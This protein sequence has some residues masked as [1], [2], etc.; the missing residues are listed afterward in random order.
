MAKW[1]YIVLYRR[2]SEINLGEE[3]GGGSV[4]SVREIGISLRR[5]EFAR[6]GGVAS[7]GA[8]QIIS[9]RFILEAL[10]ARLPTQSQKSAVP[11]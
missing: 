6:L 3:G 7:P 2:I 4:L 11:P 9:E 10:L 1:F 8:A 5:H